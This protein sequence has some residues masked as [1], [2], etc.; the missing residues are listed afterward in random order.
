[1]DF[2][3]NF[4]KK[5]KKLKKMIRNKI[6]YLIPILIFLSIGMYSQNSETLSFDKYIN[7]ILE[8]NPLAKKASNVKTYGELQYKA[9]RGNYDPTINGSYENKYFNGNFSRRS[10]VKSNRACS[11]A[12]NGINVFKMFLMLTLTLSCCLFFLPTIYCFDAYA[13]NTH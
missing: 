7:N 11:N 1:M 3:L 2:L 5:V 6:I 8:N 9:A 13:L 4:M 12:N 10:P